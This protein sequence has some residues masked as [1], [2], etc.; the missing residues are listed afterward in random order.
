MTRYEVFQA[1]DGRFFVKPRNVRQPNHPSVKYFDLEEDAFDYKEK[2]EKQSIEHC[3]KFH[4]S[5]TDYGISYAKPALRRI[6]GRKSMNLYDKGFDQEC[7][8]CTYQ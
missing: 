4:Y 8:V 6:I 1:D 3:K 5:E 2:K 7:N